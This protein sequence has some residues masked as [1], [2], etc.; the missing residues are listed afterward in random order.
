MTGGQSQ[1]DIE[2][3]PIERVKKSAGELVLYYNSRIGARPYVRYVDGEWDMMSLTHVPTPDYGLDDPDAEH[4]VN[5][6]VHTVDLEPD[7]SDFTEEELYEHAKQRR[8]PDDE[9]DGWPGVQVISVE[10]SPF[11][12]RDEI[13]AREDIIHESNCPSCGNEVR[14][15]LPDPFEECPHC[16]SHLDQEE[17]I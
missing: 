1:G 12:D 17:T 3:D 11:P 14:Q 6:R 8:Y 2:R 16:G 13:P 15:Y 9:V 5:I 4:G 10:N 7:P